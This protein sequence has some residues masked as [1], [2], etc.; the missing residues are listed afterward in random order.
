MSCSVY[1]LC[2]S[3]GSDAAMRE[4]P[5]LYSYQL[6]VRV[7]ACFVRQM[8]QGLYDLRQDAYGKM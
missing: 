8:T 1:R 2:K 7:A 4:D 6:Q 5:D 3:P